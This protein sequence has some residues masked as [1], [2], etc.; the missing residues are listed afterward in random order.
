[1]HWSPLLTRERSLSPSSRFDQTETKK[2]AT[3]SLWN[4]QFKMS[5]I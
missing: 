1:M 3:S 2:V 4:G 5:S